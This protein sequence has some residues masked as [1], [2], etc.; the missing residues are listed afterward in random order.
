M[1]RFWMYQD[2]KYVIITK[3]SEQNTSSHISQGTSRKRYMI[4]AWR[5]FEYSSGSEYTRI[6]KIS[7]LYNVLKKNATP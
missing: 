3:G 5:G 7:G 2:A 4:D 6:V 1:L